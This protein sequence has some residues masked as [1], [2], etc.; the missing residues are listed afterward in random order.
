E[1]FHLIETDSGR[2]VTDIATRL[3]YTELTRDARKVLRT[4]TRIER[5]VQMA[6]GSAAY[7]MR[8]LPYRT[9]ENVIGGVVLTFI[10]IT[11][12]KRGAEARARLAALVGNS[13]DAIIG[14]ATDGIITSWNAGAERI[15]G[16]TVEEAIGR[17]MSILGPRRSAGTLRQS[18]EKLRRGVAV[19]SEE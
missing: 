17:S 6:D 19:R 1:I 2:P 4:L 7:I 15:Y 18:L 11:K 5:E 8:I 3:L 12:R 14:I 10:D 16:Y 9:A 13:Y